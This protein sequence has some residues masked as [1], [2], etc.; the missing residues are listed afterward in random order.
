MDWLRLRKRAVE[1]TFVTEYP[2]DARRSI[3]DDRAGEPDPDL[4]L[5]RKL[6]RRV[7]VF[8]L[9]TIF[10]SGLVAAMF[11]QGGLLDLLR[12]H[13]DLGTARAELAEQQARVQSLR[14]QVE[15]LRSDP[16]ARERVAREELG[17]VKPG[18]VVF[19]LPRGED[20]E[21]EPKATP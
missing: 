20:D 7:M 5:G 16:A 11:G 6:R 19:L 8:I 2:T 12:L 13:E 17:L 1:A 4:E 3:E 15:R 10:I 18:E 21:E 9:Y 14:R